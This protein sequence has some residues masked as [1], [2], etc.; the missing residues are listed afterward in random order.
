MMSSFYFK[1]AVDQKLRGEVG[2]GFCANVM[3][4]VVSI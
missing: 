4:G 3:L 1:E 2:R